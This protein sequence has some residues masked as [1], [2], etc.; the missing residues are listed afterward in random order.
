[1]SDKPELPSAEELLTELG[2]AATV[3]WQRRL[4]A[5]FTSAVLEVAAEVADRP[6]DKGG[7][8]F[9]IAA[10]IRKLKGEVK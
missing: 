3:H 6:A 4:M 1:M 7:V 10:E 2:A 9:W 5:D 8:S